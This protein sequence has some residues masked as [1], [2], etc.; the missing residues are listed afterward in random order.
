MKIYFTIILFYLSFINNVFANDWSGYYV[1]LG[2]SNDKSDSQFNDR[3]STINEAEDDTV[4]NTDNTKTNIGLILEY[5]RQFSNNFVA[6]IK[7]DYFPQDYSK[8]ILM[9]EPI[10]LREELGKT[11][12]LSVTLGYNFEKWLPYVSVGK[13]SLDQSYVL[14]HTETDANFDPVSHTRKGDIIGVGI[15]Y[16]ISENNIISFEYSNADFGSKETASPSI[17]SGKL[18]S[19]LEIER[20]MIKI[21]K[22]F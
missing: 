1:G 8:R 5:K 20:S 13:I 7:G 16:L 12:S 3:L 4:G 18:S 17:N 11:K 15:D 2:L 6:G 21:S 9:A 19:D 22:K 14:I 10:D